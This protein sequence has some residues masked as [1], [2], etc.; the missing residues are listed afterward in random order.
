MVLEHLCPPP[1]LST[2]L[3]IASQILWLF[4]LLSSIRTVSSKTVFVK[5]QLNWFFFFSEWQQIWYGAS[6]S[7]VGAC[8]DVSS[9]V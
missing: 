5:I 7:E 1:T 6:V 3:P 9:G 8:V 4:W 2:T